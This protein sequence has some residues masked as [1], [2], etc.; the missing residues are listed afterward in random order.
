MFVR[1]RQEIQKVLRRQIIVWVIQAAFII[2][3]GASSAPIREKPE[4]SAT[5][6]LQSKWADFYNGL[7]AS[8]AFSDDEQMLW[9]EIARSKGSA[10]IHDPRLS[11]VARKYASTLAESSSGHSDGDLDWLRFLLLKEGAA[12]YPIQLLVSRLDKAGLGQLAGLIDRNQ[13]NW[14]HCGVGIAGGEPNG[15]AVW[16]RVNRIVALRPLTTTVEPRASVS[17]RGNLQ[18]RSNAP[19]QPF[20]GRPDGSVT[21]HSPVGVGKEGRFEFTI[22]FKEPGRYE[23]ELLVDVGRGPE[24]AILVPIFVGVQPDP[25]PIVAPDSNLDNGGRS[26][27]ETLYKYLN[28]ARTR[29]KLPHIERDPRLDKT[30]GAHSQ[31]M[32]TKGFFGHVSPYQGNLGQRLASNDL[33]PGSSA[34]NVARSRSLLRIHRNLM[35]SP[36]HRI[37]ALDPEFTHVGIGVAKDGEVVF[38]T[39]IFARW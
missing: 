27:E 1:I 18:V 7:T 31:E 37:N 12:D 24:T 29:L 17:V 34:E 2:G 8:V 25:R 33:F 9:S 14:S 36:S 4:V 21:R 22:P 23:I 20:V 13:E 26:P 10:C 39:E 16:I 35:G 32:A 6:P 15:R 11:I 3:C 28:A 5:T 38:A 30:A 19:I